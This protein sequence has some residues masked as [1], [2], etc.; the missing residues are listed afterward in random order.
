M[1]RET[2]KI[3]N[4]LTPLLSIIVIFNKCLRVQTCDFTL[5]ELLNKIMAQTYPVQQLTAALRV[6]DKSDKH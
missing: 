3:F 5:I 1:S 4:I 6:R 2:V